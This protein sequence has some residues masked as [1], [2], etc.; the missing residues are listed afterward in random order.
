M[1]K[2]KKEN[3]AKLPFL[4]NVNNKS[5][6]SRNYHFNYERGERKKKCGKITSVQIVRNQIS[7][8]ERVGTTPGLRA[9]SNETDRHDPRQATGVDT[10]KEGDA[11]ACR[12]LCKYVTNSTGNSVFE[13]PAG[14]WA[15]GSVLTEYLIRAGTPVLGKTS[16]GVSYS[17]VGE[18]RPTFPSLPSNSVTDVFTVP[19]R[20]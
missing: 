5:F 9:R 10:R 16:L 1:K 20:V 7:L 11:Y 17:L 3:H 4:E 18:H 15:R 2:K 12:P 13:M 14:I 6:Q 19:Q 8:M